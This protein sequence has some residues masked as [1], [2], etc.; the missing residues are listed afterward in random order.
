MPAACERM[1][2]RCN[3]TRL[4]RGM[5]RLASAPKPVEIPY[6]GTSPAASSS[7][8]ARLTSMASRASCESVTEASARA[9]AMTSSRVMP[10]VPMTISAIGVVLLMRRP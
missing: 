6:V 8:R 1:S 2:E 10:D 3:W 4:S 7:T 9:T 5:C